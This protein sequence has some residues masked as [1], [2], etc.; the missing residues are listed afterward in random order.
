MAERGGIR[1]ACPR[2]HRASVDSAVV[3]L[4]DWKRSDVDGRFRFEQLPEGKV[5]LRVVGAE[6]DIRTGFLVETTAGTKDLAVLIEPGPHVLPRIEGY[7][8]PQQT[9]GLKAGALEVRIEAK[10]AKKVPGKVPVPTRRKPED[11]DVDAEAYPGFVVG[12]A[13]PAADGTFT[14]ATCRRGSTPSSPASTGARCGI[15]FP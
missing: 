2:V 8:P 1:A 9:A 6:A 12:R 15:R 10:K 3:G 11:A 7:E 5:V 14:V 4:P 13:H